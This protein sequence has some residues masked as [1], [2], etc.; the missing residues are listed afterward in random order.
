MSAQ[1]TPINAACPMSSIETGV[2]CPAICRNEGWLSERA[3]SSA[4]TALATTGMRLAA[5]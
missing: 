1:I 3:T 5:V 2:A 4:A